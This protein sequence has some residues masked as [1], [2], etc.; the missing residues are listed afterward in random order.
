MSSILIV[1]D[2]VEILETI[3]DT[4]ELE[5]EGIFVEKASSGQRALELFSQRQFDLVVTDLNMPSITGFE[6]VRRLRAQNS[7]CAI[8]VFT[9]HGGDIELSKL[10]AL[11]VHSM[12]KKPYIN[13]LLDKINSILGTNTCSK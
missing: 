7:E 4:L 10:E 9:G 1:D 3:V 12:V 13:L 8:I 11:G 2:E 5:C 6:L